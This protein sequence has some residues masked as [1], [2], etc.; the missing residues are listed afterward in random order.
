MNSPQRPLCTG[1][2]QAFT[3]IEL[4]VVIAII[5]ILAAILF[6][7]FQQVREKARATA[8]LSNEKQLGL[9]LT[10]YVQDSDE[11]MFF[12]ASKAQSDT[13]TS[14]SRSGLVLTGATPNYDRWWNMLMPYIKSNAVFTCPD[15]SAPTLGN[16]INGSPTVPRS[17]IACRSAESLS[18][19]QIN[20]P[21]ET[22]VLVDKWTTD[23]DGAVGDSWIEAFNGDFDPDYGAT[24]NR[25]NMYKAGNR[26]QG[27]AN[28][29][30]FDGHAKAYTAAALQN[31][32]D[33]TGC[34]LIYQYPVKPGAAST[35]NKDGM[36][37]TKASAA[38]GTGGTAVEP[39]ICTPAPAAAPLP[40]F[41]QF[42]YP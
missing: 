17:Y 22:L 20:D 10:Q 27:R 32:K 42:S 5:A 23:S 2:R 4:L 40:G 28:C 11:K 6:P 34:E 41:T 1:S 7:V 19:G 35:S 18:L 36:T 24:G 33:L 16:D 8:C 38:D 39:N 9:A 12:Y 15:D 30:F 3:L 31:S 25:A 14:Q 21:V 37:V 26:H 13:V 29:I